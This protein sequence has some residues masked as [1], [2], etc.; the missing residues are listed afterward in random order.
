[1][2]LLCKIANNN[3]HCVTVVLLSNLKV[4]SC[5]CVWFPHKHNRAAINEM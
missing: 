5:L 3:L 4:E 1:M 2:S